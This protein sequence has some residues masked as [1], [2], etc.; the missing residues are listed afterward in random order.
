MTPGPLSRRS[1]PERAWSVGP[2]AGTS[3]V[4]GIVL[5]SLSVFLLAYHPDSD[6]LIDALFVADILGSALLGASL[7]ARR[8]NH[9]IGWLFCG[10][11]LFGLAA[12]TAQGYASDAQGGRAQWCRADRVRDRAAGTVTFTTSLGFGRKLERIAGGPQDRDCL[13]HPTWSQ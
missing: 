2:V 13:S 9:R 1:T 3:C 10:A 8:P 6:R 12:T 7:I 4:V 5:A 11:G